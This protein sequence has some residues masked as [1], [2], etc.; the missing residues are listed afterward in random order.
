MCK[1]GHWV[2]HDGT[3]NYAIILERWT[4]RES[5]KMGIKLPKSIE[6]NTL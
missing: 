1:D 2:K 4:L 6:E 5:K 3:G